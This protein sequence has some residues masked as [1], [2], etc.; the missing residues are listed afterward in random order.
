MH[1]EVRL[2][3]LKTLLVPLI[4]VKRKKIITAVLFAMFTVISYL[5]ITAPKA[6]PLYIEQYHALEQAGELLKADFDVT[7]ENAEKVTVI[8]ITDGDTIKVTRANG[9]TA[10]IRYIGIDTPEIKHRDGDTNDKFGPEATALN[11]WLLRERIAYLQSDAGDTDAYG[12]LLRYVY[13]PNGVMV[14]YALIRL[15]YAQ[16]LTIQ[17]NVNFQ[18]KFLAAQQKAREEK[19]V[20]WSD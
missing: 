17:P 13:L 16:L 1:Q 3:T 18:Q 12:R 19:L 7:T 20:L 4:R 9:E 15:G 14:N 8:A 11:D 2:K 6:E 5:L 10:N